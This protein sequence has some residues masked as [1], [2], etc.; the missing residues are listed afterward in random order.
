MFISYIYTYCYMLFYE[1]IKCLNLISS[2]TKKDLSMHH[3]LSYAHSNN[4]NIPY[5][6]STYIYIY[7]ISYNHFNSFFPENCQHIGETKKSS[8]YLLR[9]PGARTVVRATG[10]YHLNGTRDSAILFGFL[11]I[12][13]EVCQF[14]N[15]S[16][17][18]SFKGVFVYHILLYIISV[19]II[20][21]ET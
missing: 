21:V 17:W 10:S 8:L 2:A 3:D 11:N 13:V 6:F 5:I 4:K 7:H 20:D 19:H 15:V 14:N 16:N 1:Y 9:L 12:R 18:S